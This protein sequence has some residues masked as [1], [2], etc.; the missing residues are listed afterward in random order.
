MNFL[1]VLL[2]TLTPTRSYCCGEERKL[3]VA[4]KHF[5]LSTIHRCQKSFHG[6]EMSPATIKLTLSSYKMSDIFVRF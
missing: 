3:F 2:Y 6:D 5:L 4:H 1:D